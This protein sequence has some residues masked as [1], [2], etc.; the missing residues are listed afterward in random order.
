MTTIKADA[1]VRVINKEDFRWH[2]CRSHYLVVPFKV[3]SV[4]DDCAV[5]TCTY[6][7]SGASVAIDEIKLCPIITLPKSI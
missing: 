4:H 1:Y 2:E 7:N 3:K 6:C 5:L